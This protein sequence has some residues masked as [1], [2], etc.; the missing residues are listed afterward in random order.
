MLARGQNI[1]ALSPVPAVEEPAEQPANIPELTLEE[2]IRQAVANNSSLKTASLET[3]RAADDLAAQRTRRFANTQFTALGAQLITKPSVTFPE[4]SLGVYSATGP[5]PATNQKIEIARKPA[6]TVNVSV[7]QPLS[8]Q[9]QLHLQLKALELGLEGT[10]QDQ[11]KTRLEV[12]DQVQSAYYTVV[13]AQSAL[14]SLQ[15]SLPYY[16]ESHRLAAREPR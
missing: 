1:A 9:Y 2:A 16:Q 10:R 13:E 7:A 6:G 12:V 14:D 4:G 3:R 11:E 8:T 5:I 15:A